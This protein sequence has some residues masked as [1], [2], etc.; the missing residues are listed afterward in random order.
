MQPTNVT[1]EN[2]AFVWEMAIMSLDQWTE[3][4]IHMHITSL[5][6]QIHIFVVLYVIYIYRQNGIF[7]KNLYLKHEWFS[8]PKMPMSC[9]CTAK[10]HKKLSILL[11]NSVVLT[12]LYYTLRLLLSKLTKKL[13][14]L[15][16]VT[17]STSFIW[18]KKGW[19]QWTN[20]YTNVYINN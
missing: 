10:M 4:I 11:E 9:K 16:P 13:N 3:H 6:S 20:L 5:F 19:H 8:A 18:V 15:K 12:P 14:N 17:N 7:L 2:A 1:Y